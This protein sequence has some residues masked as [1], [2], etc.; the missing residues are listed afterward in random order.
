MRGFYQTAILQSK[1][2]TALIPL[3]FAGMILNA[4]VSIA[5]STTVTQNFDGI[6]TSATATMPSS[7]KIDKNTTA[8][9][10]GTYS[11]AGTAT[12]QVGGNSMAAGAT[13]GMYNFGAGPA[14]SATDRAVGGLSSGTASKSVNVYVDL[15]NTG[16]SSISAFNISYNVEKYKGG[17]NASGFTIQMYYSSD[18]STWTNAGSGFTTS[19]SA[20]AANTGY[21]SAPGSTTAVS[22]TLGYTLAVSSHLYLAWNYSVTSGTTTSNAQALGMDDVSITAT[23]C[24]TSATDYFRSIASGS[25]TSTSTWQSSS[26]NVTWVSACS[27]PTSAANT[28]TIQSPNTV[29]ISSAVTIDQ[30]VVNNG[31]AITTS[32]ATTV[33]INDGTGAD[34]IINGTFT[35]S[36]TNAM[37]WSGSA[38]WQMGANGTLIKTTNTSSNN[39]QDKYETGIAN[40][41]STA[42]WILRKNSS[43]NPAIST[44]ATVG[45]AYYPNLTI[46]NNYTSAWTTATSSTFQG[47]SGYPTIKGN[48][49]IGGSGTNTVDFLNQHTYSSPS[50]VIG[51]VT[52]RSGSTLSNYGTGIEIQ[53]NLVCSGTIQYDASDTR[54][55]NFTGSNAQTISGAGTLGIYNMTI[56]KS[57]NDLTLSRAITV[58]NTLT[59]TSGRIFSTATN[60]LTINTAGSVASASNSSFTSGPVRYLGGS[61]FTFPVG[62][63]S[64]YQPLG[65]SAATGSFGTF[66][67][68]TFENSCYSMCQARFYSGSNGAWTETYG[69]NE[70]AANEWFVSCAEVGHAAGECGSSCNWS[71][72]NQTD[73]SLHVGASPDDPWPGDVGAAYGA[74]GPTSCSFFA[75][76]VL[77]DKRMNSPTINCTGKSNITLAFNYIEGGDGTND[78]ATLW[79]YDGNTWAQL[80]DLAKTTTCT[81]CDGSS[82]QGY[83]TAYSVSLPSSANNNANVKIGFRWV[84]N[85]DGIGTDPSF[86]VDDITLTTSVTSDFTCEYF[87]ANPQTTFNNVLAASLDH[88]SSCEYWTLVRNAGTETKNVTLSWTA[89][90]ACSNS[91][92]LSDMRVA[93]WDTVMWQDEGNTTTTGNVLTGTVTSVVETEYGPYTLASITP[94]PLPVTLV[95]FYA[96]KHGNDALLKWTTASEINNDYF[97][98]QSS[99]NSRDEMSFE[100]IGK[101]NGHGNS[102]S[103]NDYSFPDKRPSKTGVYYYRLKQVDYDGK[104]EY[105]NIVAVRFDNS[106]HFNLES[107]I[108]NPY[109]DRT[110]VQVYVDSKSVLTVKILEPQGREVSSMTF[111]IDKGIFS[112]DP[113]QNKELSPGVYFIQL[114]VGDE[115]IT[116]RLIKQ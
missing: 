28:V 112:F 81:A 62:K 71:C 107:I 79:Y 82:G 19:F 9:S 76:C 58:D 68:E 14:A 40:I 35:E 5:P 66:W 60:L 103:T 56:N 42:N 23:T 21:A 92:L 90:N 26:D 45:G 1:C 3:L 8:R 15:Q 27:Y 73:G 34:L 2:I 11:A 70:S 38:T 52:V 29:T 37:V 116:K 86:A 24:A 87:I 18:G 20:D 16:V 110:S 77:T 55:I 59:F 94:P 83:W 46:E 95:S 75:Y 111:S 33:T 91:T 10:V 114:S 36:S 65:I 64:S 39:W 69:T 57:A 41:P 80:T 84:N 88:I 30:I 104:F 32:G 100:A 6:G 72:D 93:R 43:A 12:D 96:E 17:T 31:A 13:N 7:W 89:G 74:D 53:G 101:V 47:S 115:M 109:S 50:K 61:A 106:N 67:T 102:T 97:E 48:F 98:I 49:D 51:N 44:V 22:S 54:T 85:A 105:S 78:N 108:P 25:W 113:E 4:Q 63:S 99:A